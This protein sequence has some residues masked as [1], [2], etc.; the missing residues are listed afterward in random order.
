VDD[1]LDA[2]G[3][4][5]PVEAQIVKLHY[6][7]GFNI[8]E[9]GRVLGISS[10]TAHRHWVFARAWLHEELQEQDPSYGNPDNGV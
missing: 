4:K 8:S 1:L 9:A 6:F 7:A 10:S 3:Q 5:Y 2:L